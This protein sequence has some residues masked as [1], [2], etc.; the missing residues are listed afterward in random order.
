[1]TPTPA[2]IFASPDWHLMGFE[3]ETAVVM[4]MTRDHYA[5]SMFLDRRLKAAGPP[6]RMPLQPLLDE[7]AG[8]EVAQCGWIF[9]VALCGSTLLA[10]LLDTPQ[11]LVLREPPALRELGVEAGTGKKNR[12]WPDRVRLAAMLAARRYDPSIPTVVKA[13]V[14]VNF[15]LAELAALQPASSAVLLHFDLEPYL[16]AILYSTQH[17]TWI[18]RITAQLAPS[19]PNVPF[20]AGTAVKAAALWLGQTRHFAAL[21]EGWR[22][23]RR[24]DA[25]A[26]FAD[27][28]GAALHTATHLRD[29]NGSIVTDAEP[30]L[31][32][33][34]KKPEHLFDEEKRRERQAAAR[35]LFAAEIEQAKQWL[36]D[37]D[38]IPE[39]ASIPVLC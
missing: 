28:P 36:A 31:S 34:S 4:P 19:L 21:A 7:A 30:L 3:G 27:P 16:L 8:R 25:E 23:A 39:Q 17:R 26:F 11:S 22:G 33:Y 20:D 38:P 35:I 37:N 12:A 14:P 1:M 13:N 9:H 5:Q 6:V 32:H 15:M 2:Q 18:E 29:G 10:R 24:L